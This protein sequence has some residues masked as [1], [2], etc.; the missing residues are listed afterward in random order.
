MESIPDFQCIGSLALRS[1]EGNVQPGGLS[2]SQTWGC[3]AGLGFSRFVLAYFLSHNTIYSTN[4]TLFILPAEQPKYFFKRR[5]TWMSANASTVSVSKIVKYSP[6]NIGGLF[7]FCWIE[8]RKG[9]R[10]LNQYTKPSSIQNV[11]NLYK[12]ILA[13]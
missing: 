7:I 8:T 10:F 3:S 4:R 5:K 13:D 1:V 2:K 12:Y 11:L 6:S 9:V